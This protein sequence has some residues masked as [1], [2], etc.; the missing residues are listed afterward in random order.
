MQQVAAVQD[1][2]SAEESQRQKTGLQPWAG[3]KKQWVE[4]KP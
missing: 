1:N 4:K 2:S 3:P